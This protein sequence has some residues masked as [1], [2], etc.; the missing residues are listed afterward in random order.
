MPLKK[1]LTL[2]QKQSKFARLVAELLFE[3]DAQG[4][5]ITLGHVFRTRE[6]AKKLGFERSLHT[7]K[8]AVDLNLF[9]N[10]K[11][12]HS[13]ES[14]RTLGEWWEKQSTNEFTCHWGGRF[15]KKDGNHY[16]IGHW[17]RK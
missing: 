14:H 10:G 15:R 9:R 8:L 6:E 4:F 12:L 17:G 5:E 3:A 1:K 7:L 13:T 11:Y 16:S 2:R